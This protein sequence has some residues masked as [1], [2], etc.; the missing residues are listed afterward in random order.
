LSDGKSR[1]YS[2]SSVLDL[3]LRV[4]HLPEKLSD[5][6]TANLGGSNPIPYTQKEDFKFTDLLIGHLRQFTVDVPN[7]LVI[8]CESTTH[9]SSDLLKATLEIQ[10]QVSDCNE[11][12]F[13][14]KKFKDIDDFR[15]Q[16]RRLTATVFITG[17]IT[18]PS[19][20]PRNT[21]WENPNAAKR[22][23]ASTLE[24]FVTM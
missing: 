13:Q 20:Q 4:Q 23:E 21:V 6:P 7:V 12:F 8:K 10:N 24:H 11:R 9:E 5:T 3:E 16:F 1:T 18:R 17:R 14:H 22:F 19:F 2:L 15:E